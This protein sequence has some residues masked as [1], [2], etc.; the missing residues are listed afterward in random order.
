MSKSEQRSDWGGWVTARWMFGFQNPLG[1]KTDFSS[2]L[3]RFW[4]WVGQQK[5]ECC[6][7]FEILWEKWTPPY[8]GSIIIMVNMGKEE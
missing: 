2:G 6:S 8:K 1:R 5:F 4:G 7:D 3:F